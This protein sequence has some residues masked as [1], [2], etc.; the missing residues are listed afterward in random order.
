MH[1]DC[2]I[3]VYYCMT[4]PE[5][6]F[7]ASC[8]LILRRTHTVINGSTPGKIQ[9]IDKLAFS[10]A[11]YKNPEERVM[12]AQEASTEAFLAFD[13]CAGCPLFETC[14]PEPGVVNDRLFFPRKTAPVIF[15]AYSIDKLPN[16]V[17]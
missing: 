11:V 12:L 16:R 10:S 14:K 17:K 3:I 2:I 4:N 9:V 15:T 7:P 1:S 13:G 6:S 8:N 5:Y